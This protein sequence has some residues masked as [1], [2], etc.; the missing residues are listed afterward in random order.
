MK[1]RRKKSIFIIPWLLTLFGKAKA[2]PIDTMYR[3]AFANFTLPMPPMPAGLELA[4]SSSV[5][6][7]LSTGVVACISAAICGGAI[8][9]GTLAYQVMGDKERSLSEAEVPA[10][11]MSY[12][13]DTEIGTD[14]GIST[15]FILSEAER[16]NDHVRTS[17]ANVGAKNFSP[18]Q[19]DNNN[20][21]INENTEPEEEEPPAPV[22][23][24]RTIII[25]TIYEN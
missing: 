25:D 8:V 5:S 24:R 7:G 16:L 11:T 22:I 14:V 13:I 20:P 17:D 18:L 10:P 19:D 21:P 23:I 2:N 4:A 9:V 15:E 3:E 12:E 6:V 1:K